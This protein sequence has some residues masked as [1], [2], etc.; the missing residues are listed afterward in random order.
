MAT[1]SS[2]S[3][4][5]TTTL[6]SAVPFDCGACSRLPESSHTQKQDQ[7]KQSELTVKQQLDD[8]HASDGEMHTAN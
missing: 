2:L 6:M 5:A 1:S 3:S 4:S 7:D 8:A